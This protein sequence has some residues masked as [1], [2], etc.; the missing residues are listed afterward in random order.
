MSDSKSAQLEQISRPFSNTW[1]SAD[2]AAMPETV[3]L[4]ICTHSGDLR[5]ILITTGSPNTT[6]RVSSHQLSTGSSIFR[7][8]LSESAAFQ[9]HL[10]QP[11]TPDDLCDFVVQNHDA[12]ALGL[13]L[14]CLHMRSNYLPN[15]VS[16]NLLLEV[17]AVCNHYACA[18]AIH[19]WARL[20]MAQWE[21]HAMDPGYENWIFIAWVFGREEIFKKL[22]MELIFQGAEAE[23]G[24]I[25]IVTQNPRIVTRL[26]S[27]VPKKIIG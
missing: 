8:L 16:F 2:R 9:S 14:Y 24:G 27:R 17:T 22:S 25:E 12:T 4:D 11:Q 5:I 19:P 13:V 21:G 15:S 3:H 20:W 1:Q 26:D 7:T 6:Y 18:A 23:R 10:Q